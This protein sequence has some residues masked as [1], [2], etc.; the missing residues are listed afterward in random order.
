MRIIK[1]LVISVIVSGTVLAWT[2]AGQAAPLAEP[3]AQVTPVIISDDTFDPADWQLYDVINQGGGSYQVRQETSGGNPG[4][5][6]WMEQ[7]I[8]P[9]P[10]GQV[11]QIGLTHLYLGASYDPASQGAIA[12]LAFAESMRIV[13]SNNPQPFMRS[14]PVVVQGGRIYR[15][16]TYLDSVATANWENLSA[17]GLYEQDFIALDDAS[18]HPDFSA[19]G[20]SLSFGFFRGLSR[21]QTIPAI[22]TNQNLTLQHGIDNWQVTITPL[23]SGNRPPVAQ[24]DIVVVETADTYSI[25]LLLGVLANDFDPDGD[26]LTITDVSAAG[27]GSASAISG[28]FIS[29]GQLGRE[30]DNFTYTVSDGQLSATAGVGIYVDCGCSISCLMEQVAR[31]AA[32]TDNLDLALIRRLRDRVMRTTPDGHR[33]VEMY[34]TTTP[35]IAK[36]L[37]LDRTDLGD[38]AVALVELWQPNLYSLVD[39]DGSATITQP[40]MEAMETFLANLSTAGSTDLQQLISDELVRLGPLDDYVGMTV[41]EAKRQAIGDAV[42]YLPLVIK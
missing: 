12:S 4:A 22:P 29:Y 23:A 18:A 5:Y 13:A 14:V 9:V 19:Q 20:Q 37:M 7:V 31:P 38:E 33:Y 28:K 17:S 35:E 21:T 41:K 27:H 6:R 10:T 24:N 42:I 8:P 36:I 34:Y 30:R 32:A 15:A 1:F 16:T 2:L 11:Y 3:A 25:F 40:Q 26:N 39:G